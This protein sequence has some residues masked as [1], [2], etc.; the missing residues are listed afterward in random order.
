[1]LLY[2]T[3]TQATLDTVYCNAHWIQLKLM[4]EERSKRRM[5]YYSLCV[6]EGGAAIERMKGG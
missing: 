5:D 4:N 6:E 3:T 1:M 2:S